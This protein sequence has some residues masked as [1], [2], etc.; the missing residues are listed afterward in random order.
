MKYLL[1]ALVVATSAFAIT[2]PALGNEVQGS[3]SDTSYTQA[4]LLSIE[5][6][7]ITSN[8]GNAIYQTD[9]LNQIAQSIPAAQALTPQ[10]IE[11]LDL[12]KAPAATV[13]RLS[14]QEYEPTPKPIDPIGSFRVEPLDSGVS[15]TVSHF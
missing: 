12:F 7:T 3:P 8:K 10:P 9:R 14:Q 5:P 1:K 4:A 13:K 11:P 2:H 6:A 15:V